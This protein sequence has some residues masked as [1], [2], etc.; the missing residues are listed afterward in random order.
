MASRTLSRR[1]LRD[2]HDQA[3]KIEEETDEAGE[4]ESPEPK[5]KK[6]RVRKT[7]VKKPAGEKAPPK[8]RA[9]KKAAKLP[10]RQVARWAVYDGAYKRIAVFDYKERAE[11][12]AKLIQLREDKKGPFF[13]QMVK[14]PYDP[15]VVEPVPAI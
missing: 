4:S 1:A 12:D 2:Q 5:V 11:A 8:P 6:A 15:P 7:A 10:P 3:E 13:I 14:D 9:R